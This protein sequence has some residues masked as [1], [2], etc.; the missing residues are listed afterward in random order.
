MLSPMGMRSNLIAMPGTGRTPYPA[1]DQAGVQRIAHRLCPGPRGRSQPGFTMIELLCVIAIIAILASLLLPAAFRAYSRAK[2]M[3][4]LWEASDVE[5][6]LLHE[7]RSY[8]AASRTYSFSDKYDFA[9]KCR[10][11]PK[12]RDWLQK[13]STV[14]VAF[15]NLTSTNETVLTVHLG[16]GKQMAVYT[17]SKGE[18][19][20]R[21]QAQ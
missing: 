6:M 3:G 20:I 2:A 18:L 4:E 12:C 5:R 14:F 11:A 15:D 7:S 19:T 13:P 8:C 9:D 21:P 16:S 17:F 10:L 1:S